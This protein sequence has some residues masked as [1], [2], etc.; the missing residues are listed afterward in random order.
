MPETT[1]AF[2]CH[3]RCRSMARLKLRIELAPRGTL[4][5][6]KI[7]LLERIRECGSISAAARSIA[8][9]YRRAWLLIDELNQSFREPLISTA[10]GGSGGGGA[11]LTPFGERVIALYRD[12]ERKSY[13]ALAPEIALLEAA[14]APP[15]EAE[16]GTPGCGR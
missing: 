1:L 14:V 6:G 7:L 4:G 3:D 15:P 10:T 16:D 13:E 5:P 11:R 8:M 2:R 12:M 9:S